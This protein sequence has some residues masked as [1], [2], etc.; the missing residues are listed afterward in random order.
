[1]PAEPPFDLLVVPCTVA[2]AWAEGDVTPKPARDAYTYAPFRAWRAFAEARPA[3]WCI[4][5]TKYGLIGP[6][7]PISPYDRSAA[8]AQGDPAFG[9]MVQQQIVTRGITPT[10]R[11]GLV[12]RRNTAM[13]NLLLHAA[14]GL[15]GRVELCG[16][17]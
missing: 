14:P 1:M 6:D 13:L 15:R 9:R 17:Q 12:G 4:L 10:M 2:K 16:P 8:A 5:S 11:L 3:P 7:E